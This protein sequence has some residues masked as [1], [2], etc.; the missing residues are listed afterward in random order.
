MVNKRAQSW[1]GTAWL[2]T[3]FIVVVGLL[4]SSPAGAM[5]STADPADEIVVKVVDGADLDAIVEAGEVDVVRP[6]LASRGI[7]VVTPAATNRRSKPKDVAKDLT[8]LDDVVYAE[9]LA[10]GDPLDDDRFHAWPS[11]R[12][13]P[14]DS[15]DRALADQP[16]LEALR[17]HDVHRMATG[18]DVVVA[19]LDTGVDAN[20][21]ILT[22]HL[23]S[24]GYDYVDDDAEPA[25][26]ADGRD[27][28]GDGVAD[29]AFGHGTH[30]AGVVVIVAPEARIM[31]FRV[32]DADGR[33]DPYLVAEAVNDAVA[34]GVDVI[35]VS[36]GM[37][38][39][40]TSRVLK[41][42]F[43]AAEK[44]GVVVVAAA[45]NGGS[46]A[47]RYPAE[48]KSVIGVAA[49]GSDGNQL[50]RFSNHGKR[51]LVAAPGEDI[52]STLPGGGYGAWSGTSMAAPIVA[53]QAAL[54][55][56]LQPDLDGKKV[57]EQIGHSSTKL[58]G[59]RRVAKGHVD[60]LASLDS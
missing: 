8:K 55:L 58:R 37:E 54:I 22:G 25:E 59:Q 36:F 26:E 5:T 15:L 12:V 50:A 53:G 56:D 52:V 33:G 10:E 31:V 48:A 29:E 23:V 17:L 13:T 46:E 34:A 11:G 41:D 19:V 30:T 38:D 32:L 45:G 44:A 2:F 16:A 24:G 7:F 14:V 3:A 47:K 28:D 43:K 57:T 6:V 18:R 39:E 51:A 42:A 21:P 20:H 49:L 1:A 9:W 27:D 60:I 4:G 40:P 35:N